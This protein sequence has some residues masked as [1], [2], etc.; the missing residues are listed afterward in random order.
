LERAGYSVLAASDGEEALRMFEENRSA[1]SLVVLDAVMP[2]L[3]GHEV[4]RR[5]KQISPDTRI[6]YCT[7]YNRDTTRAECLVRENVPLIQKPF[8]PQTLLSI[9]R[10]TLDARTKCQL[11]PQPTF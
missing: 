7:G 1:I 11:K 5:I 2:K 9:V 10:K 6:V 8:T 4:R 3:T